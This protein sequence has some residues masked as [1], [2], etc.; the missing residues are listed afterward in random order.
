[1]TGLVYQG[2]EEQGNERFDRFGSGAATPRCGAP[3]ERPGRLTVFTDDIAVDFGGGAAWNDLRSFKSVFELIHSPF[4][5]T[6]HVTT[7]HQVVLKGETASCLSYVHG[8]FV[9]TVP[10]AGGNMFESAGWYDDSLINTPAA[11]PT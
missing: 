6:Q 4:E 10:G 7:N 9:R 11:S 2:S 1:V 8:R 5:S 3:K